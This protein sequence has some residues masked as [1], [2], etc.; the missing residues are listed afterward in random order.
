MAKMTAKEKL[1]RARIQLLMLRPFF[2]QLALH[3]PMIASES[4]GGQRTTAVDEK[5]RFYYN[6]EWIEGMSVTEV[7]FEIAHEVMHLVQ[8]CLY[9]FP[10]GGNKALWNVAADRIVDTIL[11]DSKLQQSA[12]SK[13]MVTDAIMKQVRGKTT[14]QVYYQLMADPRMQKGCGK[15]P[16]GGQIQMPGEGDGGPQG[17]QK[18]AH[19]QNHRGCMGGAGNKQPDPETVEEWRGKILAAAEV[20]KQRGDLPA[21]AANFI[22]D[23]TKPSVTWKSI[24][25]HACQSTFKGRYTFRRPSRRSCAMGMRLPARAP[26]KQGA[27]IA[28]DTSGSISDDELRQFITECVQIMRECGA[29][30]LHI[31]FHDIKCYHHEEYT[32]ESI[33]QIKVTRGGTSHIDVFNKIDEVFKDN[34][35]KI[36]LVIAFTDLY[37]S[38]PPEKPR[39]PVFWGVVPSGESQGVPYG[40]K[41]RVELNK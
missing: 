6:E 34:G 21:F 7:M 29:P 15:M 20:A 17:D 3:M 10:P 19:D 22:V 11:K 13:K 5:G 8:Q 2:G 35:K 18:D 28:I 33:K 32:K 37:T 41:V 31:F 25:R 30:W 39:Y 12:V 36:G 40:R 1:E 26:T 4:A 14:E 16:G 9:R 23:L 27:V 38:F 24:L